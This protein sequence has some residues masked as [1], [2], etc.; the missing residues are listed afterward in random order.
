MTKQQTHEGITRTSKGL[1]NQVLN[2]KN[3]RYKHLTNA[4]R[5]QSFRMCS[6]QRS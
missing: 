3:H 2:E 6:I 1:Y 5:P 4:N